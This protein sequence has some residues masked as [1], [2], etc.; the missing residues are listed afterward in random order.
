MFPRIRDALFKSFVL[1]FDADIEKI[2]E[3]NDAVVNDGAFHQ[4]AV[5]EKVPILGFG[6]EAH[7][8]L[9]PGTVVPTAIENH[10]FTG[11]GK[12]SYESL[13]VQL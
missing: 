4:G 9:H 6:T 2:F 10:Y 11:G 8:A 13:Q 5:D 7:D 12:M 1:L 3:E